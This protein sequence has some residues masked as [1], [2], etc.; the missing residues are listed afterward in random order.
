M[1]Q[2]DLYVGMLAEKHLPGASIGPVFA[3]ILKRQMQ[4]W[5]CRDPD[6][7]EHP[8]STLTDSQ[9]DAVKEVKLGHVLKFLHPKMA[10]QKVSL[11]C[12]HLYIWNLRNMRSL[13]AGT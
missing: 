7:F 11:V 6:F 10:V 4:E 13:M 5:R 8:D 9:R 2:M 12:N 3:A 1:V